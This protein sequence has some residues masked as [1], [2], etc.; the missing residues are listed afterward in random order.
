[1]REAHERFVR[2]AFSIFLVSLAAMAALSCSRPEPTFRVAVI[3][4]EEGGPWEARN[5]VAEYGARRV[6]G[7]LGASV[8]FIVPEAGEDLGYLFGTGEDACDLVISLGLSSSRAALEA[9]PPDWEGTLVALDFESPQTVTGG[10]EVALVRYRVEEGAYACGYLAAWLS[11][12]NDHPLT[13]SMPLVSFI[14]AR[15][16]P[17]LAYY[18]SGFDRGVKAGAP[19]AGSLD[20][21]LERE[22][23][24]KTAR[25]LAEEAV[26]KGADIIFCSPGSFN[27]E[28][29]EV[30][31]EKKV[32]VILSGSDRGEESPDHVLTSLVFRDDN[33]IFEAVRAA[34]DGDLSPGKLVWGDEQGTWSLAPYRAH[35]G[36]IGREVREGL[37]EQIIKAR[38]MDF[39]S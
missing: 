29:L 11:A 34:M 30:A 39:S 35:D 27:D 14:G 16:D 8:D 9:R 19:N 1:M 5:R 3:G 7:E 21:Y 24:I 4:F 12:R 31:S 20:Y 6:E 36:Y 10:G 18:T 33:A 38:S 22:N 26:K 15:D 13:N 32:L 28:V 17:M 2:A 23:D 37:Q 25:A